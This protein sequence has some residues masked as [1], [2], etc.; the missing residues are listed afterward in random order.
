[1]GKQVNRVLLPKAAK[2]QAKSLEIV[3]AFPVGTLPTVIGEDLKK[4][5]GRP[6]QGLIIKVD[7][8]KKVLIEAKK[9]L[10]EKKI[11]S[12][13][14]TMGV[15]GND[16]IML[17]SNGSNWEKFSILV[18]G[19]TDI[20]EEQKKAPQGIVANLDPKDKTINKAAV[21]MGK[22]L[23]TTAV[24][25]D[26]VGEKLVGI[27]GD[28]VLLAHGDEDKTSSGQIYGKDFAGKSPSW[29]VD[30]LA[31]NKDVTKRLQ[32]DYSGT[33]YIDGCFTAQGGAMKNYCRQV[34][35]GLKAAGIKNV[36]VMG[37][38]G[39]AGTTDEGDE[40]INPTIEVAEYK[41]KIAALKKTADDASKVI[42]DRVI[43]IIA[44][45]KANKT[46][47]K[48]NEE[49]KTL[50]ARE[51]QI[52]KNYNAD[53]AAIVAKAPVDVKNLVGKFGISTIN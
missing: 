48:L 46:D 40:I 27:K 17:A 43:Q 51:A 20:I 49:Y 9:A 37:N 12:I 52:T 35:D 8:A 15:S 28:I 53:R 47:F 21:D 41:K 5:V 18:A 42:K 26:K 3:K 1:M 23:N 45:C 7:E 13:L 36:K 38:L 11:D 30:L 31:K 4:Q 6:V 39:A 24:T 16:I 19:Y 44:E 34:W 25:K 50:Q 14:L 10:D 2:G 22:K 29:I 33:V 32:P